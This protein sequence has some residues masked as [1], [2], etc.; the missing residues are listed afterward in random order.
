MSL[1][2]SD[3]CCSCDAS[4]AGCSIKKPGGLMKKRLTMAWWLY[5][6]FSF[7]LGHFRL[8]SSRVYSW[9]NWGC[10]SGRDC[11][12]FCVRSRGANRFSAKRCSAGHSCRYLRYLRGKWGVDLTNF[13]DVPY[14]LRFANCSRD[15]KGLVWLPTQL[16]PSLI[17]TQSLA[18]L[19]LA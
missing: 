11:S 9:R 8:H 6:S 18:C 16:M 17:P 4:C 15:P 19:R 13:H 14:C 2:N 12:S 10:Y 1:P 5:W 7:F 3:R